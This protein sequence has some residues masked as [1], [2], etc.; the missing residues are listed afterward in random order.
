MRGIRSYIPQN[1]R[2]G[3]VE[4]AASFRQRSYVPTVVFNT[5][6]NDYRLIT[7]INCK[8]IRFCL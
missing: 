7:S 6:G 2:V 5:K 4:S 3:R 1:G 8:I